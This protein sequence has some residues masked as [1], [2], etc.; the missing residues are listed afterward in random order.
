[1]K[2]IGRFALILVALL[3]LVSCYFNDFRTGSLSMDFSGIQARQEGD[4][5]RVYLLADG[6][7]FSTGDGTPF[8]AEVLADPY[9]GATI[10]IDGLPVGPTYKA[11]VGFGPVTA[12]GFTPSNYGESALFKIS[13]GEDTSVTVSL[14]YPPFS[15]IRFSPDL[16]GKNILA[17]GNSFGSPIA[18]EETRLNY[19]YLYW[20]GFD[21]TFLPI[22]TNEQ[23]DLTGLGMSSLRANGLSTGD[24]GSFN[25]WLNTSSGIYPFTNDTWLFQTD[26]NSGLSG[27]KDIIQSGT[28][29]VAQDYALFFR[30]TNG[31]GGTYA[32]LGQWN[33]PLSWTWVN[34]DLSGVTDMALGNG[35]A[36]FAASGEGFA[37]PPAFVQDLNPTVAKHR[38]DFSAPAPILSLGVRTFA[39]GPSLLYMGT[40]DGVWYMSVDETTYEFGVA[41]P[42]AQIPETAGEPIE[43]IAISSLMRTSDNQAYLS[44][45]YLFI[46]WWS[47]IYKIP[48]YAV[49][50]GKPTGIAWDP[51]G[52]LYVSGTEG[53]AAVYVG[54]S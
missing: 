20:D 5:A 13:P 45:Y 47:S 21:Y 32:P 51:T 34:L 24:M 48:F 37:L 42:L 41:T 6:L 29:P 17:V 40:T 39:A 9:L 28:V 15:T 19:T 44:R 1:M 49:F 16:M 25:T 10:R 2:Q 54:G 33:T 3:G 22:G 7:L 35:G 31:L 18:A 53:L 11:L 26:F 46:R 4:V 27:P 38:K 43:Q 12:T 8:C 52:V 14:E 50:P 36:Y 30:R 23:Y